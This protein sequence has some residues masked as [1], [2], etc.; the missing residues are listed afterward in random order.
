MWGGGLSK[1][2]AFVSSVISEATS[3]ATTITNHPA[4]GD[5]NIED[6]IDSSRTVVAVSLLKILDLII[7]YPPFIT[8]SPESHKANPKAVV[9]VISNGSEVVELSTLYVFVLF[10]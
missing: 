5:G 1:H 2:T 3:S 6:G 7:L 4:L 8:K 9:S 10:S